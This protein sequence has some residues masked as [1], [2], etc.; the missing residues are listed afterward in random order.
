MEKRKSIFMFEKNNEGCIQTVIAKNSNLLL[1]LL[2]TKSKSS[3]QKR[4]IK[5]N[6]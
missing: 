3:I 6:A 4:L 5:P 1:Y 2:L